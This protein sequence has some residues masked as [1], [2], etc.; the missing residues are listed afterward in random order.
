MPRRVKAHTNTWYLKALE[1]QHLAR[2]GRAVAEVVAEGSSSSDGGIAAHG[3]SDEKLI[4]QVM[5]P[6][7]RLVL[8][9]TPNTVIDA[10][11]GMTC[12]AIVA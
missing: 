10:C 1:E 8:L 12:P 4:E 5:G 2:S 3:S 7:C 6:F 9:S 11:H